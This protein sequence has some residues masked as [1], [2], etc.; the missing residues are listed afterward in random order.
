MLPA[1]QDH[2]RLFEGDMGPNTGGM[3]AFAPIPFLRDEDIG[4]IRTELVEPTIAGMKKDGLEG[5]GV[6][7]FGA[8]WTAD[9]PKILEYNVRFGD[10]ETQVLMQLLDE[11]LPVLLHSVAT[12][13]LGQNRVNILRDTAI[14]A[15]LAAEGYPEAPLKGSVIDIK[16]PSCHIIHAGTE[17]DAN[18][19]IVGGGR[20]VNLVARAKDLEEARNMVCSD[21]EEKQVVWPGMQ[22]RRDIGLKALNHA[23]ANKTVA[24]GWE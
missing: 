14:C 6:L 12:H 22:V 15:V 10:P 7:F 3:G 19:W 9:G 24:D 21:I 20:A 1:C 18:G 8:M 2:K 5:R 4:R 23:R 17:K 13:S 16:S 11:D